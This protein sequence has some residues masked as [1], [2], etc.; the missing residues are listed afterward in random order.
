[1]PMAPHPYRGFAVMLG[2]SFVLMYG[3]MFLNVDQPD[4]VYLSLTRTY[5]S[6]LMVS[7]MALVMLGLM[8]HM[9]PD[10][11]TNQLIAGGSAALFVLV[12]L[13]L[14]AQIPVGDVQY[15]KAMIP[16]HSSAI[17][18]SRSAK[19][20]DPQV[21]K[22]AQDIIRSQEREIAEMK[23]AIARLNGPQ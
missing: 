6:L 18:V 2:I 3:I 14:R 8:R 13:L 7:A 23:A 17:M 16:H 10:K 5:M 9:Y 19:L 12:L 21:Q 20:Q 15:M 4:H 22:L 11:R 1:M